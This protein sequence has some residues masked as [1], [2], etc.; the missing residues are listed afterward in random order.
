M[1]YHSIMFA[2]S[3]VQSACSVDVFSRRTVGALLFVVKEVTNTLVVYRRLKDLLVFQVEISE[4]E[5]LSL[6]FKERSPSHFGS[7]Q[8][9]ER[10]AET[11][12]RETDTFYKHND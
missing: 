9:F 7:S 6:Q 12:C 8:V 11:I 5:S 10:N 2:S 1:A 3:Y 4:F